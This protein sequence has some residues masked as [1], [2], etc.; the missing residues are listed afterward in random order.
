MNLSSKLLSVFK[1]HGHHLIFVLSIMSL[2][3]LI[4]WWSVFIHNSIR[5]QRL[6]RYS[7]LESEIN[8]LSLQ[9]GS[10]PERQPKTGIL[11]EDDRFE[12]VLESPYEEEYT[13]SLT[14]H[15]PNFYLRLRS[16]VLEEIERKSASQNFMLLGEA[17]LLIIIILI[18][19]VFL[20]R[21]IRLERQT[22]REVTE[23]WERSAHEIKTP[24]TGIKAFLQNLKSG[25]YEKDKIEPY[26]DLAL[27]HVD[28]QEKLAENIL[29]GFKLKSKDAE[30]RLEEIELTEFLKD[31][32]D[33]SPL[34]F[35]EVDVDF[36]FDSAQKF[37]AYA[38]SNAL[39]I[40]LDNIFD[41]AVKYGPAELRIAVGIESTRKKTSISIQDNGPGFTRGHAENIFKAY[42]H[43]EK[44][45]PVKSKGTGMG[46][47]ISRRLARI[48]KGDLVAS[49]EGSGSGAVFRIVLC[50]GRECEK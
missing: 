8:L 3:A 19:S 12:V 28:R 27:Q 1:N 18:S 13:R 25:V 36:T 41:N 48:M 38:D 17:S 16:H 4:A 45:L 42:K 29:S 50:S 24:I 44:G 31:Y 30:L 46:L 6:H 5:S 26:V 37:F 47:F 40:I 11:D 34:L 32:V 43:L 49:S 33:K 35:S 22:L 2:A 23:F 15:W 14:P 7:L 10:D 21:Y 39:K 20:Y 9:L